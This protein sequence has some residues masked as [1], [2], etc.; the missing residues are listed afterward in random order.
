MTADR[1][2]LAAIRQILVGHQIESI[3]IMK[4][5]TY[6]R[7]R[8]CLWRGHPMAEWSPICIYEKSPD[9]YVDGQ[10]IPGDEYMVRAWRCALHDRVDG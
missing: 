3:N 8:W 1:D 4:R 2:V 9:R 5:L 6:W 7:R 10:I